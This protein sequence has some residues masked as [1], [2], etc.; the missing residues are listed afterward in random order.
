[1]IPSPHIMISISQ[2]PLWMPLVSW[3]ESQFISPS[4]LTLSFHLCLGT[5]QLDFHSFGFLA[6]FFL[7]ST[8]IYTGDTKT[9][10]TVFKD[11]THGWG[12]G[13]LCG[14]L[15][16]KLHRGDKDQWRE[17]VFPDFCS[18]E[19][20]KTSCHLSQVLKIRRASQIW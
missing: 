6:L 1:M 5:S 3:H 13:V 11:D 9:K 15:E 19:I 18:R 8:T 14:T 2:Q 12:K 4:H 20:N 7:S 17:R 10:E 16:T